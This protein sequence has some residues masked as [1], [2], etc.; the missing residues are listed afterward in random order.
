[1]NAPYYS[2]DRLLDGHWHVVSEDFGNSQAEHVLDVEQLRQAAYKWCR[3]RGMTLI[4]RSSGDGTM[5]LIAI[6]E[7]VP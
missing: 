7:P 6:T 4:T 5:I 1:M 2:W 3:R